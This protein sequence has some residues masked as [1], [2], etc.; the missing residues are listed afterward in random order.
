M[1]LMGLKGEDRPMICTQVMICAHAAGIMINGIHCR[2][3][4]FRIFMHFIFKPLGIIFVRKPF[5][6]F[7]TW[8]RFK[9]DFSAQFVSFYKMNWNL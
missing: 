6:H 2:S 3:K 8:S 4:Y 1:N 7:F 9:H 5:V